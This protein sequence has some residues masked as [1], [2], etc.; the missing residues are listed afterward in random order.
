[1]QECV[2]VIEKLKYNGQFE[3]I[4]KKSHELIK[5]NELYSD[6]VKETENKLSKFI[7]QLDFKEQ[8]KAKLIDQTRKYLHEYLKNN[9]CVHKMLDMTMENLNEDIMKMIMKTI[10][11]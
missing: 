8:G 4:R 2:D 11:E 5:N 7:E 6:F 3:E 10:N 9:E 1:M